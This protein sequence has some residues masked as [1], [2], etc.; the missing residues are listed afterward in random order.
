M[1]GEAAKIAAS[2]ATAAAPLAVRPAGRRLLAGASAVALLTC[3]AVDPAA[4]QLAR[5][6]GATIGVTPAAT[7]AA[8][9]QNVA[10]SIVRPVTRAE[11]LARAQALQS[12]TDQV[13]SFIVQARD[14]AL[15]ATRTQPGNGMAANGLV[16]IAAIRDAIQKSMSSD[17]AVRDQVPGILVGL[18]AQRDATGLATWHNLNLPTETVDGSRT[19]VN[20][21]QTDARAIASWDRFDIGSQTTLRITQKN[22]NGVDQ[23]GWTLI[24]RVGNAVAPSTILGRIEAPGTVLVLNNRGVIFGQGAQVNA[25]SFLASSLEIGAFLQRTTQQQNTQFTAASVAERNLAFLQNGL[26]GGVSAAPADA[27]N[28]ATPLLF[29]PQYA[30]GTYGVEARPTLEGNVEVDPGATITTKAGGVLILAAPTIRNRGS[31][32]ATDGQVSLQ[33]G[34][35]INYRAAT[36]AADSVDP[37]VRGYVL[38]SIRPGLGVLVAPSLTG[39]DGSILNTGLIESRRGYAS[40]GATIYGSVTSSGLIDVTTSVSRNGKIGLY[41]GTVTLTGN[42]NAGQAGG[43]RILPDS[44]GETIP[45]GTAQAPPDFKASAIVVSGFVDRIAPTVFTLGSNSFILAPGGDVTIG[46]DPGVAILEDVADA[47]GNPISRYASGITIG[48]NAVIDVGGVKGVTVDG[49]RNFLTIDPIKRNELRDTPTYRETRTD[50]GFTLN[51]TVLTVDVRKTGVRADGVR[52]VGSPLLEAGSA[53]SQIGVTAAELLTTGGTVKLGVAPVNGLTDIA[54]APSVQVAATARLDVS[55][56]WISYSEATKGASRLLTADGRVIDIANA[57]PNDVFVGVVEGSTQRQGRFGVVET[58]RTPLAGTIS[59]EPAYEEGRDAGALIITSSALDLQGQ[60]FGNA[61]AGRV[62]IGAG[63]RGTASSSITFDTRALQANRTELPSG[64]FVR[65]GSFDDAAG[66]LPG[67]AITLY[68]GTRT[69]ATPWLT[70]M[71]LNADM[72]SA[73]GLSGLRLQSSGS[74]TFAGVGDLAGLPIIGTGDVGLGLAPGGTLAVDAGRSIQFNGRIEA[75]SGRIQARTYELALPG[76]GALGL[77]TSLGSA[78]TSSDDLATS[79][80]VDAVLPARTFDIV[81]NG[82]LSVAGLWTNSLTDGDA[83]GGKAFLDGG[84]IS[85]AVAPKVL[86]QQTAGGV[87]NNRAVDLSGRIE[88]APAAQLALS[89]GGYVNADRSFDLGGRGGDLR[90]AN[91]T[92]YASLQ[93]TFLVVQ[94]G[95]DIVGTGN[96]VINGTNQTVDFT[97]NDRVVAQIMP[98]E[99]RA[100]VLFDESS[101]TAFGFTGGGTFE[102]VAPDIRFNEAADPAASNVSLDVLQRTGFGTLALKSYRSQF[103]ENLFSNG[104]GGV[105]AFLDTTT[106]RIRDGQT[107]DL[108]QVELPRFL[109]LAQS[110]LL[111]DLA[112]G[113]DVVSALRP[114]VAGGRFTA[115]TAV[116]DRKAA[117]LRLEGLTELVVDRG[118]GIVTAAPGARLDVARLLNSGT[119]RLPGGTIAQRDVLTPFL[120]D[121][122][123]TVRTAG[124]G[125]TGLG[126]VLG[127][128]DANGQF[129]ENYINPALGVTSRTLFSTSARDSFVIFAG[130]LDLDEGVRLTAG[131]VT[132]LSGGPAIYDPRAAFRADGQLRVGLLPAGG[133]LSTAAAVLSTA[134]GQP[135]LFDT[136]DYGQPRTSNTVNPSN[137]ITLSAVTYARRFTADPGSL[138]DLSGS[139]GVFDEAASGGRFVAGTEWSNGGTLSVLGGGTLTPGVVRAG[140]GTAQAIGGTLEWL[141]PVLAASSDGADFLGSAAIT[142]AGFDTLLARG[143][144]SVRGTVTLNLDKALLVSSAPSVVGT[145]RGSLL[146]TTADYAITGTPD[147][148]ATITAPYVRFENRLGSST[149]PLTAAAGSG[150]LTVAAGA[151]GLDIAGALTFDASLGAVQLTSASDI[152]FNGVN[153]VILATGTAQLNG[154]VLAYGDLTFDAVRVYGTTG[155]GN[156]QRSLEQLAAGS[157]LTTL[158]FR[159][160]ANTLTIAS[161]GARASGSRAAPLSAGSFLRLTANRIVQNGALY[162]PLGVLEIGSN[163]VATVLGEAAPTVSGVANTQLRTVRTDVLTFGANSLTSVSGAGL[164]VPYGTTTDLTELFFSPTTDS[165][166]SVLPSGEL[167]LSAGTISLAGATTRVDGRGGGETFAFEFVSGVGGSRDV[168]SRRNSDVFSSNAYDTATGTGLQFADGRQVFALVPLASAGNLAAYDPVYSSDYGVSGPVDLYG[169]AAGQMVHLEAAPG[170]AGG[171]YLLLP[172]HYALLPGAL[173]LVENVGAAAP[174]ADQAQQLL[175]GSYVVAGT[176]GTAGTGF[177]ESTRRSFTIQDRATF[178]RYAR[179]ETTTGTA[180]I[181]RTADASRLAVGRV[182]ADAARV[183]LAPL[184]ALTGTGFFDTAP[185]AGGRGAEVDIAADEIVVAPD[186]T[187]PTPGIVTLTPGSLATLSAN[188]L[189]LGGSRRALGDG[190]TG[191]RVTASSLTIRSGVTLQAPE[192]LLAVGAR[193]LGTTPRLTIEAGA[194]VQAAGTLSNSST[195]DYIIA[196]R[197]TNPSASFDQTG[198]GA[199]IRVANGPERLVT[200]IGDGITANSLRPVQLSLGAATITGQSVSLETSGLLTINRLANVSGDRIALSGDQ[201]IFAGNVAP[202]QLARYQAASRLTLVSPS[203]VRFGEGSFDFGDLVIDAPG[204][205]LQAGPSDEQRTVNLVSDSL[206]LRNSSGR[207]EAPCGSAALPCGQTNNRLFVTTGEL[208]LGGGTYGTFGFD[209]TVA[210]N[211]NQ[212]IYYTDVGTLDVGPTRLFLTTPF[213]ADRRVGTGSLD[214]P[215]SLT[216]LTGNALVIDGRGFAATVAPTGN[217]AAGGRINLGANDGL[218]GALTV[219]SARL[220]ATAGIIDVNAREDI[221]LTGSAALLSPGYRKT[222]GDAVDPYTVVAPSGTISLTSALGNITLGNGTRLDADDGTA[223]AGALRLLAGRGY[224]QIA[225]QLNSAT[226]SRAG[227]LAIDAGRAAPE[228]VSAF[229]LAGFLAANG[230][231]FQGDIDIRSGVGD[232]AIAAGQA[233]TATSVR[234][235]A[236]GGQVLVDGAITTA[237]VDVTLLSAEAARTARIDGGDI[238]LFGNAGVTLGATAR[239]DTSTRGFGAADS[240]V[241]A[242]GDVTIG[243]GDNAEARLSIAPGAV[244]DVAARRPGN[245]L[246]AEATRDPQTLAATTAY[247]FVE[248]DKGGNVLLR[249]PVLTGDRI[250]IELAGSDIIRGAASQSVEGYRVYNLDLLADRVPGITG[251]FGL[252]I[253]LNTDPDDPRNIFADDFVDEDLVSVPHFVRNFAITATNGASLAAFRQRPGVEIT[254]TRPIVL[255]S[256]WNLAAAEI[257]IPAAVRDGLMVP[258]AQYERS[259]QPAFAVV[260]GMEGALLERADITRFFY[261]VGGRADGEAPIITIRGA[262]L[263]QNQGASVFLNEGTTANSITDGFFNFRD[264]SDAD[265]VNYRLGGGFRNYLPAATLTCGGPASATC[266]DAA[267]FFAIA[268]GDEAYLDGI[269][270]AG[271]AVAINLVQIVAGAVPGG[272]V[273]APYSPGA[274]APAASPSRGDSGDGTLVDIGDPLGTAELFPLINGGR[275]TIRSSSYRIIAGADLASAD[276]LRVDRGQPADLL[277]GST[278]PSLPGERSYTLRSQIFDSFYTSQEG[279]RDGTGSFAL[280]LRITPFIGTTQTRYVTP[281]ADRDLLTLDLGDGGPSSDNAESFT[282]LNWGG[283]QGTRARFLRENALRYFN[284][285]YSA[286]DL[287]DFEALTPAERDALAPGD[288]RLVGLLQGPRNA[289]TGIGVRLSDALAFLDWQYQGSGN[290]VS[291]ELARLVVTG[292]VTTTRI[293][294]PP[295]INYTFERTAYVGTRIRTGDGDITIVAS[296]DVNTLRSPDPVYRR[297]A[298]A[299]GQLDSTAYL[300]GAA[301]IYTAGVRVPTGLEL[302]ATTATAAGTTLRWNTDTSIVA[303]LS[304]A[305]FLPTP[306]GQYLQDP[307]ISH[308]GGALTVAA[309]RDV[310]GRRDIYGETYLSSDLIYLRRSVRPGPG[311]PANAL[312]SLENVPD[313]ALRIGAAGQAWRV[314]ASRS[315]VVAASVP[316]LF[317]S[318]IGALAGGDV[319]VSAGRDVVELTVVASNN[320]VNTGASTS[321]LLSV[322]PL[323]G[324]TPRVLASFGNGDVAIAAGRDVVGGQ[325]D[326]ASGQARVTAGDDVAAS[327]LIGIRNNQILDTSIDNDLRLRVTDATV[328]LLARAS[329]TFDSITSLGVSPR[330]APP[331]LSRGDMT[332]A[333]G[334]DVLTNGMVRFASSQTSV[335]TSLLVD[336]YSRIS[337]TA[338]PNTSFLGL[339]LPGSLTITAL[340]GDFAYADGRPVPLFMLPSRLGQLRILSGGDISNIG[341]AM[342]DVDPAFLP[343]NFSVYEVLGA[344]AP[345]GTGISQISVEFGFPAIATG[346]NDLRLRNF[347]NETPTH[348]TNP[349]PVR[350]FA[351]GDI[352]GLLLNTPKQTRLYAGQDI[353]NSYFT[354]QNL[355]TGDVTRVVAGRD[356]VGRLVV[357]QGIGAQA[358]AALSYVAGNNFVLGGPGSLVVQ[359]GRN[360]GPF[361]SSADTADEGQVAG[362]IRTIGNLNN[363]WLP[364]QGADIRTLFGVANGADYVA[365]RE[366]YLNPANFAALDGDLF[367]QYIDVSG[368]RRPLNPANVAALEAAGASNLPIELLDDS[369]RLVT[370]TLARP[371]VLPVRAGTLAHWLQVQEPAAYAAAV[372]GLSATFTGSGTTTA[373]QLAQVGFNII[374]GVAADRLYRAFSGLDLVRQQSFLA[375]DLLFAELR[376]PALPNGP[377][378]NQFIRGYRAVQTLFPARLGYTDNL[379]AYVTDPATVGSDHPLGV[380]VRR[381][382]TDGQPLVADRMLTGNADLRLA[383]VQTV[384]GGD[385]TFVAPGGDLIAGSVVRASEQISRRDTAQ[386]LLLENGL[387]RLAFN[388]NLRLGQTILALPLGLEG[389]LSLQSGQLRGFFDGDFRLNQSRAFSIGGGNISFWSSNGDLNAG[390]GPRSASSFPPIT[391]RQSPDGVAEVNSIGSVSGAGI[392][393]FLRNPDDEPASIVL[394]APVGE[395]D[396]GD[397]GVRASGDIFVAAARVANADNFKASGSVSGVPSAAGSVAPPPPPGSTATQQAA[398]AAAQQTNAGE[399]RSV[400]AVDV[401]GAVDPCADPNTRDPN[402]VRPNN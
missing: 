145:D 180:A 218:L 235:T 158:P 314:G 70:D 288:R 152:R 39:D 316:D 384:Q 285:S 28:L 274:N 269:G 80:D 374:A 113:S 301:A 206:T 242:A 379:A 364:A 225:G 223:G 137:F 386:R 296:R 125:G 309:G 77:F 397:A 399:R 306:R 85:L 325:V 276:P 268:R 170:F 88:I 402:C 344:N 106:F 327:T 119:I 247:R 83:I 261:R 360:L 13:R 154:E 186:G 81:V 321:A 289:P 370:L 369:G 335:R 236:D 168:L 346:L 227:S 47:N 15:A 355:A 391:I 171:D 147:A 311:D 32:S 98:D 275:D 358:G 237:G 144:F 86:V 345:L 118:G 57:D 303:P 194:T 12:R 255:V 123:L 26:F 272:D 3:L 362:G 29:A 135:S 229:N 1:K 102:L 388:A 365:L 283:G 368:N 161:T 264:R 42:N 190:S 69:G 156:L 312:S 363:P 377:S 96:Q 124:N 178:G 64:A 392:G 71:L 41:A 164:S 149:A 214:T 390:Q 101:I 295:P 339:V 282:V 134:S 342:S 307:V 11:A 305:D 63:T 192:L 238:N 21:V 228:S 95:G 258:V 44:N 172:G 184:Q 331:L 7:A 308:D 232:L 336:Y 213:I 266:G 97:Q 167:R 251:N 400:I 253:D 304:D 114:T 240:R 176:Y 129:D 299:S 109:S 33:A 319:N 117:N 245:R 89:S 250:G 55:G 351:D 128:A 320:A 366:T 16:P 208:T 202:E 398:A 341:I 233:L 396:A 401:L 281:L 73:A 217:R 84:S 284:G 205:G 373:E 332:A 215:P 216:I 65:I 201:L 349:E 287:A 31:L 278:D 246:V 79:Y 338:P 74:V 293:A 177:V 354:G 61:Y 387:G 62:Q 322:D 211:A 204:I 277:L 76:G 203:R 221:S 376:E 265:Y 297:G 347:H 243:I 270:E 209:G 252:N 82:T 372:A 115:P 334:L 302:S 348:L 30:P 317:R 394:V 103:F 382:G 68:S 188:S 22:A 395:V 40:L 165:A 160:T 185:A 337:P 356:I 14:A 256:N 138:L 58:T 267:D 262:S 60:I 105:S 196:T 393:S 210:I 18:Q 257:D 330:G 389:V 367:V 120:G 230:S 6:R 38:D 104:R 56:G 383:T 279:R 111:R 239:L 59:V 179:I 151:N 90:L 249:A 78:F 19:I 66:A 87:A 315:S 46:R 50:G 2:S 280:S 254:S 343:G 45:Q 197:A 54:A 139:T 9:G 52:W 10:A 25:Y 173:R 219:D 244:I 136:T 142:G 91:E 130:A 318:G 146:S 132:D 191:L 234:L 162:A 92:T 49:N 126:A 212:G 133:T 143:G 353:I 329:V 175:D 323:S 222:F 122:V 141:R 207:I 361:L 53:V 248:S 166:L 51:G 263:I 371:L 99:R 189:F 231:R 36:G 17:Q 292:E 324:A 260:P 375:G 174:A 23:P 300:V 313:A 34:R 37:D 116:F 72:L 200:R 131:S 148:R 153:D 359:A 350:L 381:I 385:I 199:T 67:A 357:E 241:A 27:I 8:A 48:D 4:A 94:A 310:L 75:A 159:V 140:G 326:I 20:L 328:S 378:F 286:Q 273:L 155:T 43:L 110:T 259:G 187:A 157:A 5:L 352:S 35:F 291:G 183:V 226:G 182:P 195:S 271:N 93:R 380:P 169:A 100:A 224:V 198:V 220:I 127:P 112:S 181:T 340:N 294:P 121:S 193:T 108:T 298:N 107:L 290:T 24:N 333:S 163:G 150:Q